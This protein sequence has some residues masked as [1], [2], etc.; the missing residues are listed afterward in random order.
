MLIFAFK[1]S[2]PALSHFTSCNYTLCA[3]HTQKITY[4]FLLF[5][6]MFH[7]YQQILLTFKNSFRV[8]SLL[9][10][11]TACFPDPS[12]IICL[13]DLLASIF[14]SLQAILMEAARRILSKYK[15]PVSSPIKD[16]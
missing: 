13:A 12:S 8:R 16:P 1:V 2:L 5:Y 14:H 4:F 15:I 3:S 9:T 11:F 10:I 7:D 6:L